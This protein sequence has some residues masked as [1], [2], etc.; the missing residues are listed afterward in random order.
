VLVAIGLLRS[1]QAAAFRS[2]QLA[3]ILEQVSRRGR[4]VIDG[5]HPEVMP[6]T[7]RDGG[8]SSDRRSPV[9]ETPRDGRVVLWPRRSSVL[10]T[11]DVPRLLRLAAREDARIHLCVA[12][13]ETI[14][15]QDRVA[16]VSGGAKL[17]DGD[18]LDVALA[19]SQH[20]EPVEVRLA[21]VSAP[22]PECQGI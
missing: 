21:T 22:R 6:A 10:Q 12:P 15:D 9:V 19:P 11:V 4:A 8:L 14:F 3:S 1:F 17:A 7:D 20:R 16:V 18:V 13:G 5:V 2:I